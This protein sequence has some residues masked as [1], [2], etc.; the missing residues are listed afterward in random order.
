MA[1][2][3]LRILPR[4]GSIAWVSRLRACLA[5]PPAESPSTMKISVPS[6]ASREQSA[7]LPG[8]RSFR[9]AVLRPTSSLAFLRAIRSSARRKAKEEVGRKTATRKLRLPGKLADCARDAR[10]GTEL[11]IVEGDSA[12]GSAKQARNRETQ[13]VLPL[14]G[15]ILNVAS[16]TADK[17]AGNKE[18]ADLVTAL[19]CGSG[20]HWRP[21]DLRY[22]KVVIMTDADV[23]GAHIAALLMTF[24]FRELP[25]LVESGHLYLAQPPLYRLSHGG[26]IAYA[27]DE[28]DRERLL[29]TTFKGK[30]NVELGR[31]K[32]LGEMNPSQLKETTMDP[33]RRQLLQVRSEDVDGKPTAQLVDELMG[34]R[35]ELRL[36]FIQENARLVTELDV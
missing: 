35:P 18:L 32:G 8:R 29:A 1:E 22:D 28:A 17:L 11:F 7:S 13:A 25:K 26:T 21:D 3:T 20:K 36:A 27:R 30:K 12:G 4:S 34:R 15:K 9:V 24:F 14:R 2:A 33:A 19:G 16:A 10:E 6:R 23:D 31:F 5:E